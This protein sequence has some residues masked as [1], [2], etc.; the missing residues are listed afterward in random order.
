VLRGCKYPTTNLTFAFQNST[1]DLAADRQRDIIREAFGMWAAVSALTFTEVAPTAIPTFSIA[2]HR[3]SHGDGDPFDDGGS[4]QGNVLAHAFFPPLCGGVHAG[5]LHFDEFESW[6]DAAAP[7]AI[8]LLNVAIH[9]VGHLLGLSHSNVQDAIMFAFYDDNVDRL[10]QD[11]INGIQALYGPRPLGS[12]PIRGELA[13]TG[14]NQLHRITVQPGLLTISLQG[15]RDADFDLYVRAGAAP[16]R[17]IFDGRGFIGSSRE[18]VRLPV[19]GGE[20]FLMVDSWRG[21][22]RYEVNVTSQA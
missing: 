1:P 15:P 4:I 14:A 22:G 13:R 20:V 7:R 5:A 11:D 21:R 2:F 3:G 17:S 8:R 9:E 19:S 12:V 18:Q 10:R 6:T 16:S